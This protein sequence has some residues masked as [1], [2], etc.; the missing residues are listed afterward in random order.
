MDRSRDEKI[1]LVASTPFILLHLACLLALRTGMSGA[2]LAVCLAALRYSHVRH[3]RGIPPLFRPSQPT[4][5]AGRSSSCSPGWGR[6]RLQ[7]G[8]LWW[9]AHHRA[10]PSL[11]RHRRGSPFAA[12]CAASGGRTSAGF[13]AASTTRR[14]SSSSRTGRA[15]PN[16]AC[17]T[18]YHVGA[19]GAA[20]AGDVPL[21]TTARNPRG[22]PA[23]PRRCNA[24]LGL[25]HQHRARSTTARFAVNSL[26]PRVR[27]PPLRTRATTAA[28]TSSSP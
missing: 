5:P 27:Q 12:R 19:A 16:C 25:L 18:D 4:K 21:A 3:H 2:A 20:G 28:T 14:T 10:A 24:G 1:D 13:S 6:W 11:L 17:W 26:C 15:I 7:K 23:T 8:P 9:A 22:R